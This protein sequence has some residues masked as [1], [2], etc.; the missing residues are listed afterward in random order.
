MKRIFQKN[1]KKLI[2]LKQF[3]NMTVKKS[4][5]YKIQRMLS[6]LETH[7]KKERERLKTIK[8]FKC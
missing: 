3:I 6:K 2:N 4:D 5:E 8:Y 7:N 1:I